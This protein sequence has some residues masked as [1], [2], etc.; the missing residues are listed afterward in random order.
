M[1]NDIRPVRIYDAGAVA[2][3]AAEALGHE[4]DAET[5]EE[6]ISELCSDPS[7]FIRVFVSDD[8]GEVRGFIQAEKYT[9]I[10]GDCGYNIIALAVLPEWQNRGVGSALVRALEEHAKRSGAGYVRVNSRMERKNAHSFYEY[11]GYECD[12]VQKR[13]IKII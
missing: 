2:R 9:P 8:D 1:M 6:R 10:Y 13:F 7:C 11:L 4:T 5:V 3:I 12:K